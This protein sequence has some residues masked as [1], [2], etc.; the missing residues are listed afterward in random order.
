MERKSIAKAVMEWLGNIAI[1]VV[2]VLVVFMLISPRLG[3]GVHP[4]L[5]GS[6]EPTLKVGG[7]IV[8]R[9]VS[10]KEVREGDIISYKRNGVPIT[11]RV[12]DIKEQGGKVV[13]RT[14]GDA[15]ED[16]DPYTVVPKGERI[17]KTVL[18]IPYFGFLA[19]LMRKRMNFLL[20]VGAPA[21]LLIAWYIAD[22]FREASREQKGDCRIPEIAEKGGGGKH[23]G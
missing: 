4:V 18:F 6:M 19:G 2:A 8:T 23:S 14:K 7:V 16:P 21:V 3:F 9:Q 13:F 22:A 11:H 5:S 15:N 17:A 1:G 10:L 20:L 12:I